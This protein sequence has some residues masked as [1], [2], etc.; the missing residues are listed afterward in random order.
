MT[1]PTANN[2]SRRRLHEKQPLAPPP[3]SRRLN[4]TSHNADI[5]IKVENG[6]TTSTLPEDDVPATEFDSSKAPQPFLDGEK[7]LARMV[8][9][10]DATRGS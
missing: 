10:R 7:A 2:Q 6:Q 4:P 1:A 3:A 8:A 9:A 5:Q